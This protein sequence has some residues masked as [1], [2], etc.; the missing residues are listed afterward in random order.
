MV[1]VRTIGQWRQEHHISFLGDFESHVFGIEKVH[2]V[3]GVW[4]VL[5]SGADWQ[6][7]DIANFLGMAPE[8]ISRLLSQL[9]DEKIV[10]FDRRNVHI[11]DI[12]ELARRSCG[13]EGQSVVRA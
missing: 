12:D 9:Q 8:T 7:G 1:G 11:M 2:A 4:A 10:E 3:G 13:H 6:D 5:L